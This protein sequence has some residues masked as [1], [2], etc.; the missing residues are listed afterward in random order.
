MISANFLEM[1]TELSVFTPIKLNKK[2]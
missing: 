1:S 2:F